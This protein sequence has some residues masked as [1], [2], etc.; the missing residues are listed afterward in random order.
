[1]AGIRGARGV[2]VV[3]DIWSGLLHAYAAP[4]RDAEHSIEA[5]KMPA[6]DKVW[7]AVSYT[8]LTLP[9]ICSV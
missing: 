9:T 5:T 1:M 8:H 7:N 4:T 6:G 2:F 3:H